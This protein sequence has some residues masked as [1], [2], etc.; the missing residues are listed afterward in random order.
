MRLADKLRFVR[1]LDE[2]GAFLITRSGD[3]VCDFLK[4]SKYTLYR[5]L[6]L[7][8]GEQKVPEGE[9]AGASDEV[10]GKASGA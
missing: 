1:F 5:Y 6:E 9:A 3:A 2:K 10:P 8:R 7:I 4:I